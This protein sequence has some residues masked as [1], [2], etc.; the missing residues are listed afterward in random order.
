MLNI[1]KLK[2]KDD[3]S[4]VKLDKGDYIGRY[5]YNVPSN[6]EWFNSAYAFNKNTLKLL[7]SNDNI[8]IA[9][10]KS[11]FYMFNKKLENI[12]AKHKH[13]SIRF[14]R[15]S[16]NKIWVS[17]PEIKHTNDKTA[18]T[19]YVYNKE[20]NTYLKK[21][22][23]FP[24]TPGIRKIKYY[25]NAIISFSKQINILNELLKNKINLDLNYNIVIYKINKL[26]RYLNI[27]KKKANLRNRSNYKFKGV[28]PLKEKLLKSKPIRLTR[29][30]KI[31]LK[32]KFIHLTRLK[33]ILLK[34]KLAGVTR[35]KKRL[36]KLKLLNLTVLKK[37]LLVSKSE[38]VRRLKKRLFKRKIFFV[39]K[40]QNL[41]KESIGRGL[42]YFSFK[43]IKKTDNFK[44]I[45]F[46]FILEMANFFNKN[47]NLKKINKRLLSL[48][49]ESINIVKYMGPKYINICIN[50]IKKNLFLYEHIVK[51][52]YIQD[53]INISKK[54]LKKEINYIKYKQLLLFNKLKFK[55]TFLIPLKI[56]I[57]KIYNKEIEFNIISLKNLHLSGNI[58]SQIVLSKIKNRNNIP[59]SVLYK[60]LRKIK[61]PILNKRTI[62]RVD[63]RFVGIQNIILNN[64]TNT[65]S[66]EDYLN[67]FIKINNINSLDWKTNIDDMV[68]KN[69]EK[70]IISGI[71]LKVSGR[72]TRRIIAERSTS[73]FR[74]VGTLKNVNS[75]FK[76]LSS[77]VLRGND[78]ANVE[79]TI[80][81][82]KN[83]IGSFG[84]KGWVASY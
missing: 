79:N 47:I 78:K 49:K 66:K 45:E 27:K 70:K 8:I 16:G 65:M 76:G 38:R 7:P 1:I 36:V 31:L 6:K 26:F 32:Y 41:Y 15:Q 77:V 64:H 13:R 30:K 11:Y 67:N 39:N 80:L 82:S 58:L 61:T 68:I 52:K 44:D 35:L 43:N 2:K 60:T 24:L 59:L 53:K 25:Y 34:Y 55:N 48:S 63:T 3:I 18:I 4:R 83:I 37:R 17:K 23:K 5:K 28:T 46:F 21:L 71:F 14:R 73:K 81:K 51:S 40:L 12:K 84:L 74:H 57:Q 19:L 42:G 20:Y 50:F 56:I 54:K 10:I 69:T 72:I 22:S 9:I 33:K 75:S 29:L 62:K